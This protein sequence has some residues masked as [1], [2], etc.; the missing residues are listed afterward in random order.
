MPYVTHFSSLWYSYWVSEKRRDGPWFR[1]TKEEDEHI[2]RLMAEMDAWKP[3]MPLE[4]SIEE[5]VEAAKLAMKDV[6]AR[7]QKIRW[8]FA[9][10]LL[11]FIIFV[12]L[13]IYEV[14][15]WLT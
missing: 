14:I 8:L 4:H 5:H 10:W 2:A 3:G 15:G 1:L 7:G 13:V 6:E 12:G 11:T 9:L